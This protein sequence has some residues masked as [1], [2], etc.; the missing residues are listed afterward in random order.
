M[1]FDGMSSTTAQRRGKPVKPEPAPTLLVV[2]NDGVLE[3]E[4]NATPSATPAV[5]VV[6]RN[7]CGT[8][9][10]DQHWLNLDCCGLI[11]AVFTYMLHMY[12]AYV[13]GFVLI[14]PWMSYTENNVRSLSIFGHFHRAAFFIVAVLAVISH[15]NAMTTDPGAVPPDAKPFPDPDDDGA[16][17]D[18]EGQIEAGLPRGMRLCRRCKAFKPQRAHHCSVCRRCIIKMVSRFPCSSRLALGSV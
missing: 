17:E 7:Y 6:K 11:C 1:N 2:N 9:P 14:P 4:T 16:E 12:G 10:F 3:R 15:F 8:G 18:E 5:A 13:V